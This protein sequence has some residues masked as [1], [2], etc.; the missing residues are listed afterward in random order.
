MSEMARIFDGR[1]KEADE[2]KRFRNIY[3]STSQSLQN[4]CQ[5]GIHNV[6]RESVLTSEKLVRNVIIDLSSAEFTDLEQLRHAC[7]QFCMMMLRATLKLDHKD[8]STILVDLW[9]AVAETF[10][11]CIGT[12]RSRDGKEITLES[13]GSCVQALV[14]AAKRLEGIRRSEEAESL[15][16][17]AHPLSIQ[18]EERLID[19]SR[20]RKDESIYRALIL[21]MYLCR[22]RVAN[23]LGL[24]A[25]SSNNLAQAVMSCNALLCCDQEA[26]CSA[27][28][29]LSNDCIAIALSATKKKDHARALCLY[30]TALEAS[31][32][33]LITSPSNAIILNRQKIYIGLISSHLEL[34]RGVDAAKCWSQLETTR[35]LLDSSSLNGNI[36]VMIHYLGVKVK[37][38]TNNISEAKVE[39]ERLVREPDSTIDHCFQVC[40]LMAEKGYFDKSKKCVRRC[41]SLKCTIQICFRCK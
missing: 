4:L 41:K 8:E 3:S 34:A 16:S 5:S 28:L 19:D 9:Q 29:Q 2:E 6:L 39:A 40:I 20:L 38:V 14:G 32:N 26:G 24:E 21:D 15:L 13:A 36:A 11:G 25:L 12:L 18:I 30:E 35:L 22:C 37:C 1:K 33:S 17:K 7:E 10:A 31:L 23:I 27:V